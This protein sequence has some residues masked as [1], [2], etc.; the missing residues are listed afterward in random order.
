MTL[1]Y[2]RLQRFNPIAIELLR[3][4]TAERGYST[5]GPNW[6]WESYDNQIWHDKAADVVQPALA[7]R[8]W[9]ELNDWANPKEERGRLAGEDLWNLIATRIGAGPDAE[10]AWAYARDRFGLSV[11]RSL[12]RDAR[13]RRWRKIFKL[14]NQVA[15]EIVSPLDLVRYCRSILQHLAMNDEPVTRFQSRALAAWAYGTHG[16]RLTGLLWALTEFLRNAQ[17][18]L[19]SSMSWMENHYDQDDV[20]VFWET[21]VVGPV[22]RCLDEWTLHGRPVF[23]ERGATMGVSEYLFEMFLDVDELIA[24]NGVESRGE[25]VVPGPLFN[26][27]TSVARAKGAGPVGGGTRTP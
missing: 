15:R 18:A 17:G 8:H 23:K 14:A 16:E 4:L 3:R 24:E 13:F 21:L 26:H 11:D 19:T 2:A 6:A 22:L 9:P 27:I 1:S 12:P 25:V 10:K 5:S 20:D 7:N